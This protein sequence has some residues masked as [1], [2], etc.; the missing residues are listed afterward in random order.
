MSLVKGLLDHTIDMNDYL[1]FNL[2]QGQYCGSNRGFNE[3]GQHVV[4]WLVWL[5]EEG[6]VEWW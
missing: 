1:H 4:Q 6:L 3:A 2:I 5:V